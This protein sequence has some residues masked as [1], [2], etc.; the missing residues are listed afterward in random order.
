MRSIEHADDASP[1]PPNQA[2]L[3]AGLSP[4]WRNGLKPVPSIRAKERWSNAT[5]RRLGSRLLSAATGLVEPQTGSDVAIPTVSATARDAAWMRNEIDAFILPALESQ[6]ISPS[7]QADKAT[8]ARRLSLTLTGLPLDSQ[9]LEAFLKDE[10]PDAVD[11]L[12][13]CLLDSPRFGERWGTALDGCR[14]LLGYSRL[15]MGCTGQEF[16]ALSR[17]LDP[18]LQ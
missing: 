12:T 5:S 7:L 2:K 13:A 18:R 15:R 4:T 16:V 10:S 17:L 3:P 9:K 11:R 1:M 14:A 6:G 8:L